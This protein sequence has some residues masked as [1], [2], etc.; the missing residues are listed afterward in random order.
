MKKLKGQFTIA[1][2]IAVASFLIGAGASVFGFGGKIA[3]LEV[4]NTQ[5]LEV[6]RTAEGKA[7]QALD[8]VASINESIKGINTNIEWIKDALKSNGFTNKK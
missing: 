3:K 7:N 4:T 8:K 2:A 5:S 1:T 6:A